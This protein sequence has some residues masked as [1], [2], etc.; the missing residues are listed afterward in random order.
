LTAFSFRFV[1]TAYTT[2]KPSRHFAISAAATSGGSCR[3]A[4]M[5]ITAS[6]RA[7]SSPACKAA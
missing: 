7:A 1:R 4:S 6:P 3:S 5:R 2:S